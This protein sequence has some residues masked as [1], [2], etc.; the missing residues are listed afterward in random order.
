MLV[1]G[2]YDADLVGLWFTY[3]PTTYL[4][5]FVVCS[6]RPCQFIDGT[7]KCFHER[8]VVMYRE[9]CNANTVDSFTAEIVER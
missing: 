6:S 9:R 2:D 1:V 3:L 8:I 7:F 4:S 5:S